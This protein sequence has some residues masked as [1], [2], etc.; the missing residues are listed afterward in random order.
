MRPTASQH[1]KVGPCGCQAFGAYSSCCHLQHA[2]V[3]K[4]TLHQWLRLLK[5]T[6]KSPANPQIMDVLHQCHFSLRV[7][8]EQL[9]ALARERAGWTKSLLRI[10]FRSLLAGGLAC[11]G[12]EV[13]LQA[14][15]MSTNDGSSSIED[16]VCETARMR[17]EPQA[18]A[19]EHLACMLD[20]VLPGLARIPWGINPVHSVLHAELALKPPSP[21]PAL[22]PRSAFDTRRH[23][24]IYFKQHVCLLTSALCP[25]HL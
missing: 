9:E 17:L 4:T 22:K 20:A 18:R 7:M 3:G 6:G 12:P 24:V 5:H 13:Q 15:D 21:E 19:L 1:N 23:K 2:F 11:T 14:L 16:Y 8:L 10:T 25:H